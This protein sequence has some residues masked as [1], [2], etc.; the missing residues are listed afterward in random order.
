MKEQIE[1]TNI[2]L[3]LTYN[4][5]DFYGTLMTQFSYVCLYHGIVPLSS[6]FICCS[7]LF[8]IFLSERLYSTINKR[9]L[10]QQIGTIGIWNEI[11]QTIGFISISGSALIST[12]TTDSL[13]S[14][15]DSNK[16]LA[17]LVILLVDQFIIGIQYLISKLVNHIPRSVR[18]R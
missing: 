13:D 18:D 1:R 3:D 9:S 5:D 6:V 10:S 7:N 15:L 2:M 17:L 11:F 4:V 16:A 8:I 12:Y 14:Y